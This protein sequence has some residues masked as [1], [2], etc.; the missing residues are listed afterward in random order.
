MEF[1][2]HKAPAHEPYGE[3][4]FV[5]VSRKHGRFHICWVDVWNVWKD[6]TRHRSPMNSCKIA[7]YEEIGYL[8]LTWTSSSVANAAR[9]ILDT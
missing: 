6:M 5:A 8:L 9:E 1:D 3:T 2:E 4:T 7:R